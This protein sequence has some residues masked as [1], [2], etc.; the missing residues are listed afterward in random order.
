MIE[1]M[2]GHYVGSP[3]PFPT[4]LNP[5]LSTPNP[6]SYTIGQGL[7][8]RVQGLGFAA[9]CLGESIPTSESIAQ[10]PRQ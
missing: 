6:T 4:L 7:G 10:V 2:K 9:W 8:F 1:I 3:T 5:K